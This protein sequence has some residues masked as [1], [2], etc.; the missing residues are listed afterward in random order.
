MLS[1][2]SWQVGR[3]YSSRRCESLFGRSAG[4]LNRSNLNEHQSRSLAASVFDFEWGRSCGRPVPPCLFLRKACG[5]RSKESAKAKITR[6]RF[7]ATCPAWSRRNIAVLTGPDGKL[8][9]MLKSSPRGQRCGGSRQQQCGSHQTTHQHALALR[10]HRQRVM[11]QAAGTFWLTKY[12][13]KV[14]PWTHVLKAGRHFS[15]ARGGDPH[16]CFPR[17]ARFARTVPLWPS[18]RPSPYRF[19]HLRLLYRG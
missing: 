8:S 17:R 15:T 12:L 19:G 13:Q 2:P 4:A 7:D 10:P 16:N 18:T 6:K 3:V 9:W 11:H 14:F 1:P 5:N